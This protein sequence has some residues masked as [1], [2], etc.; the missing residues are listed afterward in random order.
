MQTFAD[1]EFILNADGTIYHLHLRPDEIADTI[2]TVGDPGRVGQVSKYFDR[3]EVQR[4]HREFV[5]HTGWLG[6]Q[7]LTVL[8]TGIGTD[9]VDIVLNELDALANINFKTR[10]LNPEP[11]TLNIIRIGTSGSISTDIPIGSF[12]ASRYAIGLDN[13]LHFYEYKNTLAELSLCQQFKNLLPSELSIS[14]PAFTADALLFQKIPL[15]FQGITLTAPGFYAPQGRQLRAVSK[16][17][18]ELLKSFAFFEYEGLHLTNLEMETA[19]MY[20]LCATLGHRALSCNVILANRLTG[21]FHANPVEAVE[22]LIQR[23]LE[24]LSES[25]FTEL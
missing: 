16:F 23:V 14:P 21:E 15:D 8:S 4:A 3:M 19:G 10:T 6:N 2:F 25:E 20:G 7:R 17:N 1:S 5:T 18:L 22:G 12:L 11:K 24:R 13:L 9:N